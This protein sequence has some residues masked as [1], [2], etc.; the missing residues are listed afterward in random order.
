MRWKLSSEVGSSFTL[1][2]LQ[3][4]DYSKKLKY[5]ITFQELALS[6]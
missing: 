1:L 3:R 4:H 2:V 5:D 6:A